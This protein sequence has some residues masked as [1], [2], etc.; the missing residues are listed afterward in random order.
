MTRRHTRGG[1]G[2]GMVASVAMFAG[3]GG[4]WAQVG[5]MLS[6]IP[7]S[8]GNGSSPS[9][10]V[11]FNGLLYFVADSPSSAFRNAVFMSNGTDSGT[12][13]V[14]GVG[15]ITSTVGAS[16]LTVSGS[17]LFF[18]FNQNGS[19]R[20]LGVSDGTPAGTTTLAVG[21]SV[22][23]TQIRF[24]TDVN[25]VLYFACE[26]GSPNAGEELWKSDGTAAGTVRVLDINPSGADSFPTNLRNVGGVLLFR[27]ND[28]THGAELWRSDGT[29]AGTFMVK[30][31]NPGALGS[32]INEVGVMGGRL[33]FSAFSGVDNELWVSDGTL[34]GTVLLKDLFP[35]PSSGAPENF[36]TA[37]SRV[38][39]T[40]LD[41]SNN[42]ELWVSDGTTA[43]TFKVREIHP[44]APSN[45]L[46]ITAAGSEVYFNA[47]DGTNG[48]ELWKSDG[49]LA[50]TVLVKDFVPGL[51]GP[52][53]G[54]FPRPIGMVGGLMYVA[55][56][57]ASGVQTLWRT[58]GTS[59]G[60]V[61]IPWAPGDV[62]SLVGAGRVVGSTL[63]FAGTHPTR[64][65][66]LYRLGN[67]PPIV[68]Q[69][70]SV[71]SCIGEAVQFGLGVGAEVYTYQ[72][73]RNG[74]EI[75]FA[76]NPTYSV[77][78]SEGTLGTYDCVITTACGM[79]T[80]GGATLSVQSASVSAPATVC[81]G[82]TVNASVSGVFASAPVGYQWR[83]N[84]A[85]LVNGVSVSGATTANLSIA[86]YS[87][88]EFGNLDCVVQTACGTVDTPEVVVGISRVTGIPPASRTACLG[89]SVS[90]A[91]STLPPQ[92]T[93]RWQRDGVNLPLA[94]YPTAQS[95]TLVLSGLTGA[96]AGSYVCRVA[97]TGCGTIN[98]PASV[99]DVIG[100]P[101]GAGVSPG[102]A[103]VCRTGSTSVTVTPTGFAATAYAWRRNGTP[104]N[105]MQNASAATATLLIGPATTGDA[106]VYDCVVSNACGSVTSGAATIGVCAADVNCIGGVTVQDIFDFFA[107]YFSGAAIADVNESGSITV[108]D[109]FDF[110]GTYF[111][112]C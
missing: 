75:P 10:F 77:V 26:G 48:R 69:P 68:A 34:A 47:S 55:A 105:P 35:G 111:G 40:A 66:E 41:T 92:V 16:E 101:S 46:N 91:V 57:D 12:T 14:A 11:E 76:D 6:D 51:G 17:R 74:E 99:L 61:A 79:T 31:I 100:P 45:P 62:G 49:T 95:A 107:A 72:W 83:L 23:A 58:D 38:F 36:V 7:N 93:Y 50:G 25:G 19:D 109:I 30:D 64:G 104:I 98:T 8:G 86:N 102:S 71:V 112:G 67:C 81:A 73:R 13:Q 94:T 78:C 28:G 82:D 21:G 89:G 3:A 5:V 85:A 103:T 2:R 97:M 18:Y 96:D 29:A 80:S 33:F 84:G 108:Q 37:G 42:R 22:P 39:F 15:G 70:S 88:A 60:T 63:Y 53:N 27:A 44:T 54:T 87:F 32:G 65:S 110:L 59:A 4:A 20:V 56:E 52:V 90:F 24:L 9:Q 43:G 1:L 106:G